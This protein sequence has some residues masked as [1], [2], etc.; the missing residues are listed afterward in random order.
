MLRP[1][2]SLDQESPLVG[3]ESPVHE[4]AR[5]L[6]REAGSRI[7]RRFTRDGVHP[8]D[9]IEWERRDAVI[10][11]EKDEVTFEQRNVEVPAT[12]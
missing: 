3:A 4:P 12:W 1:D 8:Y 2:P 5:G 6:P 7:P 9:E 10:Q 11:N